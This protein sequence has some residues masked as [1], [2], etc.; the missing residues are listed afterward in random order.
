M[1]ILF[2]VNDLNIGG[3]ERQLLIISEKLSQNDKIF[4]LTLWDS[5]SLRKDICPNIK[6]ISLNA[7]KNNI[8]SAFLRLLKI[9][10]KIKPDIV[11]S[12][13][14]Y[15]SIMMKIAGYFNDF[16]LIVNQESLDM[17]RN[18]VINLLDRMLDNKVDFYCCVSEEVRDRFVEN[19]KININKTV[20]I[21]NSIDIK[22]TEK[23]QKTNTVG[24][25]GRNSYAKG[26]DRFLEYIEYS[27]EDNF[28]IW[29]DK[30]EDFNQN[31]NQ[32]IFTSRKDIEVFFS[33]VDILIITS[34]WEGFPVTILESS[35][36][37]VPVVCYEKNGVKSVFGEKLLYYDDWE[38]L[39]LIVQKLRNDKDY[40]CERSFILQDFVYKNYRVEKN[41]K[42]LKNLYNK[43]KGS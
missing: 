1:K 10:R 30:F 11:H 21:P 17:W 20:V 9:L 13:L 40:Y 38:K 29:T 41:I 8:F 33:K 32:K 26:L 28:L 23:K 2:A 12:R 7:K 39:N 34:R 25:L 31:F 4:I 5:G 22:K 6:Y 42:K 35:M 19:V 36:Y 3:A 16:K 18:P 24:F 15:I 43:R 14:F 37:G 27:N